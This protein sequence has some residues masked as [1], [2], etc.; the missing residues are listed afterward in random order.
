MSYYLI[1]F[2]KKRHWDE[3]NLPWLAPGEVHCDPIT[4]LKPEEGVLS[5]WEIEQDLSN[6][7]LVLMAI[8][9]T[10][11]H[12]DLIDYGLFDSAILS[13]LEIEIVP[14]LG[15]TPVPD[16]NKFH[17]DLV[18][19]TV[20]KLAHF[21][22]IIF[23]SIRKDRKLYEQIRQLIIAEWGKKVDVSKVDKNLRKS[24]EHDLQS[25]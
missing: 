13:N 16:A 25:S 9:C 14:N 1:K 5:I 12:V 10:R 8:A 24:I 2:D 22:N 6:L 17:R 4:D 19:L 7:D 15:N 23:F 21:V 18:K 20:S 3:L 11:N